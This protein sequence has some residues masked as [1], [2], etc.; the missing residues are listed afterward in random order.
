M[1]EDESGGTYILDEKEYWR[2][3][4]PAAGID[5]GAAAKKKEDPVAFPLYFDGLK[6]HHS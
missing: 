5:H 4:D 3:L 2:D 6:V 1:L